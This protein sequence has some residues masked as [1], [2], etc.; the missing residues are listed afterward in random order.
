[1]STAVTF[2]LLIP[3][4]FNISNHELGELGSTDCAGLS[5]DVSHSHRLNVAETTIPICDPKLDIVVP[6]S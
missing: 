4:Y 5:H 2:H 1:M 6:N 3:M